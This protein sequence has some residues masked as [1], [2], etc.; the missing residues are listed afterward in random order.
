M[1]LLALTTKITGNAPLLQANPQGVSRDFPNTRRIK[2]ITSK[3]ANRTDADYEETADLEVDTR[4]YF[5]DTIGVYVPTHWMAEAIAMRSFE[6]AKIGKK[7]TRGSLFMIGDHAPL[8]YRGKSRVKTRKD[9][10]KDPAFRHSMLLKQGQVRVPKSSPIFHEW[11]FTVSMEFDDKVFDRKVLER[12]ISETS[13]YVGF[14]DFRPTFGRAS[15]EF[16]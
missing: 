2:E 5:N 3:K 11:S 7:K 1:T 9:I 13:H 10:T 6:T 12:I 8:E 15:A 14:G 4:L 16:L